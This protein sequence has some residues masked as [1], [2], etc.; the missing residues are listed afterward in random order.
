MVRP[1]TVRIVMAAISV[2]AEERE[3]EAA[4]KDGGD[5]ETK[6]IQKAVFAKS[7]ITFFHLSPA[8]ALPAFTLLP[9]LPTYDFYF[10][11]IIF[12]AKHPPSFHFNIPPPPPR[13]PD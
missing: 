7:R 3:S 1:L 6:A 10:H 11:F 5:Y 9:S 4:K 2:V 12:P 13:I 8:Q